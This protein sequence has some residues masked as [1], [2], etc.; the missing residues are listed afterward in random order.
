MEQ[1]RSSGQAVNYFSFAETI[2]SHFPECEKLKTYKCQSTT[3]TLTFQS[4]KSWGLTTMP[5]NN[6]NFYRSFSTGADLKAWN[7][8]NPQVL[9]YTVP[10]KHMYQKPTRLWMFDKCMSYN[11]VV[12]KLDFIWVQ[13]KHT[14]ISTRNSL[15]IMCH[16]IFRIIVWLIQRLWM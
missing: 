3:L 15:R 9:Y 1:P 10:I 4:V 5:I 14:K 6:W 12:D 13:P 2:N 11:D 16:N 8:E 7:S